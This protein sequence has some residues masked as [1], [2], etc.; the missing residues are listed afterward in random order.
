MK[1]VFAGQRTR[2]SVREAISKDDLGGLDFLKKFETWVEEWRAM[3][4]TKHGLS[5]ETFLTT[6][7]TCLGLIG[8]AIYLLEEK[9]FSYVLLGLINSDPIEKR[10]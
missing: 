1:S 10:F 9:E 4:D 3:N 2:D 7:Q 6:K 5:K 8:V